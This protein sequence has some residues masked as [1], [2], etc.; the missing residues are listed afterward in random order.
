MILL[1]QHHIMHDI[2]FKA[3]TFAKM[4]VQRL[5]NWKKAIDLRKSIS[6]T[7]APEFDYKNDKWQRLDHSAHWC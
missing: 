6:Y 4:A 1:F 7:F 2:S 5:W 3:T